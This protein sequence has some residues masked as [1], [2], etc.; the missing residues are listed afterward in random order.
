MDHETIELAF[1]IVGALALLTQTAILLAIY[2]GVSKAAKSM[3]EEIEDIRSSV[4]PVVHT[5]RKLMDRVGPKVEQTATDLAA[6]TRS[7]RSQAED[8]ECAVAEI[9]ERVRK[10]TG[11]IDAMFSSTLDA[12]DKAS[13]YVT[14]TVSKPVRQ[15]SGILASFKAIVESLRS[16]ESSFR[17]PVVHDDKDMFV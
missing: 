10:E 12:V 6:L 14:Q 2:L 11:R 17:E 4:M 3:K 13:V 1:V 15:L 7:L 8:M 16:S 9:L 5:T